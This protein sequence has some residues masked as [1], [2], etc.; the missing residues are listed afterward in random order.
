MRS[1][2]KPSTTSYTAEGK[3]DMPQTGEKPTMNI[4]GELP[5]GYTNTGDEDTT[6]NEKM[7]NESVDE[8][9]IDSTEEDTSENRNLEDRVAEDTDCTKVSDDKS[10]TRISKDPVD[11]TT[12]NAENKAKETS[13]ERKRRK[14]KNKKKSMKIINLK[15]SDVTMEISDNVP[16]NETTEDKKISGEANMENDEVTNIVNDIINDIINQKTFCD[17]EEN[18]VP[19]NETTDDKKISGEANKENDKENY[20]IN[21]KTFSDTVKNSNFVILDW[22]NEELPVLLRQHKN[23]IDIEDKV[24]AKILNTFLD[25]NLTEVRLKK[26]LDNTHKKSNN[27]TK[28]SKILGKESEVL[29]KNHKSGGKKKRKRK[30]KGKDWKLIKKEKVALK[31][32]IKNT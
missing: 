16:V 27:S 26:P 7:E 17:N 32:A 3:H 24:N 18:N 8:T 28:E 14:M 1:R 11:E 5:K 25:K 4:G 21:H 2:E 30:R 10:E 12:D 19:V 9:N 31:K 20:V 13:R 23:I 22:C 15:P 29:K 6:G